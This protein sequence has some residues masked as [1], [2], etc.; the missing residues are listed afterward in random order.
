MVISLLFFLLNNISFFLEINYENGNYS[1]D[2]FKE[3]MHFI[4]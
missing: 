3:D 4:L 1:H 2:Q